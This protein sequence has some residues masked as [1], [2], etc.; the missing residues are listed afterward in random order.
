MRTAPRRPAWLQL[1]AVFGGCFVGPFCALRLG[2]FLT[3]ESEIVNIAGMFAFA[4]IF[5][6]GLVSWMGFGIVALLLRLFQGTR[7]DSTAG[8]EKPAVQVPPGYRAFVVLGMVFGSLVGLLAGV[9]TPLSVGTA[10]SLWGGA[11]VAYG[12]VLWLAAHHAYLP[13]PEPE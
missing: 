7:Q 11:G 1:T 12:L 10:L 3:P 9:F 6:G 4:L 2:A 8:T 13:F 5:V